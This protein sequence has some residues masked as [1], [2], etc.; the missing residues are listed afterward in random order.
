M[1]RGAAGLVVVAAALGLAAPAHAHTLVPEDVTSS[2]ALAGYRAALETMSARGDYARYGAMPGQLGASTSEN[3]EYLGS[4]Q[5][6]GGQ[7]AA[8]GRLVG[9]TFFMSGAEH[10]SIYDVSTPEEPEL[11]SRIQ[12]DQP[13]FE[14]EDVATNGRIL[15]YSDF[16]TTGSLYVYDVSNPREPR[17]LAELP[18]AGRHTMTC[19]LDCRFAYGSYALHGPDGSVA[20]GGSV[21]DLR[22]PAHPKMLGDWTDNGVLPSGSVHDVAEIAPGRVLT[23]SAPMQLLDLDASIADPRVVAKAPESAG[24]HGVAWPR[25]GRDRFALSGGE[26]NATAS[27]AMS[28]EVKSYDA[29]RALSTGTFEPLDSF[30]LSNGTGTD[31]NP[32]ANAGLGCSPHWFEVRPDFEDG[33][34]VAMG[35][36]DHGLRFLRVGSEGQIEEVGRFL[37]DG[38]QASAAYWITDDVVYVVDYARG[39]DIVRFKEPARARAGATG[40]AQPAPAS[41]G[42]PPPAPAGNGLRV[43]LAAGRTGA[44]RA[45]RHGV[46]VRLRCSRA[47]RA[48]L[49]LNDAR[50][51]VRLDRAGRRVLRLRLP[52]AMRR[53]LRRER[54]EVRLTLRATVVSGGARR[55]LERAVRIDTGTRRAR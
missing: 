11:L 45:L 4:R 20:H 36:Y 28:A 55:V 14:N 13:R 19:V 53:R 41:S 31:G 38:A 48:V 23:A 3:V 51:V 54:G 50:R 29:A 46:R 21:I 8:G 44:R 40:S 7:L 33:G 12:F 24:V 26:T 17:E 15:L 27:C 2:D 39:L 35:S 43:S 10:I 32:I 1:G 30:Q 47:C 9:D 22:D 37:A 42:T 34:I 6:E 49:E 52:G 25:G 5:D 16:A 18:G